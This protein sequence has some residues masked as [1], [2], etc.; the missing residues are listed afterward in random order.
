M[1]DCIEWQRARSSAGY[2]QVRRNGRAEYVHRLTWEAE[3]GPLP[4]SAHVLHHCDN[5]PCYNIEHLFVGTQADNNRDKCEKKRDHNSRKTHCPQG[6]P[7]EGTNLIVSRRGTDQTF[8]ACRAC[9]YARIR[10]FKIA[11]R[12][13]ADCG[14]T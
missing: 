1:S 4:P 11:K 6:H 10:A 9:T 14:P 3:Y 13:V 5:P 8:R 2:G 12:A 7:Y